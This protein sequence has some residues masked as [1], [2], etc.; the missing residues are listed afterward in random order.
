MLVANRRPGS[1]LAFGGASHRRLSRLGSRLTAATGM[2]GA[3]QLALVNDD[4][5]N[6][7][8]AASKAYNDAVEAN[9]YFRARL[10]LSPEG[11]SRGYLDKFVKMLQKITKPEFSIDGWSEMYALDYFTLATKTKASTK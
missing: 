1:G 5:Q 4:S 3:N 2:N 8:A 9:P 7:K 11:H 10:L 6:R